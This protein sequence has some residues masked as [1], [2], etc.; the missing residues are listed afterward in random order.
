M[1]VGRTGLAGRQFAWTPLGTNITRLKKAKTLGGKKKVCPKNWI[2]LKTFKKK[3]KWGKQ[4]DKFRV[5]ES[6]C[7]NLDHVTKCRPALRAQ[8]HVQH[9]GAIFNFYL[10]LF[11][12]F[13]SF[14]PD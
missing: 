1:A 6:K 10:L 5:F 3:K 13:F 4:M 9:F 14:F 8:K 11:F 7:R 2:D 12:L